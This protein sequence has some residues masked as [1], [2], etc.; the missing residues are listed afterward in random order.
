MVR[1]YESITVVGERGQITI[2]K[3]IRDKEGLKAKDRVIVKIENN[4]IVVEKALSKKEKD[5]LLAEYYRKYAKLEDE[6]SRDWEHV[7][8]EADAMLDD[9]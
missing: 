6:T 2:P 3:D 8:K 1:V 5:K 9:Y 7:S 4:Q